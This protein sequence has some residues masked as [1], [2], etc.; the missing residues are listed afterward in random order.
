MSLSKAHEVSRSPNRS[1]DR[2][3]KWAFAVFAAFGLGVIVLIEATNSPK[4]FSMSICAALMITYAGLTYVMPAMRARADQIGDNAY[5]LGL[6]YTLLSLAASIVRLADDPNAAE[7]IL[8]NFGIALVTTILGITLR[9]IIS[10]MRDD[11]VDI[12][13]ETRATLLEATRQFREEL[14]QSAT[15][16]R[17]FHLSLRQRVEESVEESLKTLKDGFGEVA[18]LDGVMTSF[19]ETIRKTAD[20][21]QRIDASVRSFEDNSGAIE[22][23]NQQLTDLAKSLEE[24]N[25]AAARFKTQFGDIGSELA[26][27]IG[28]G[29]G[30]AYATSAKASADVGKALQQLRGSVKELDELSRSLAKTGKAFTNEFGETRETIVQVREELADLAQ[31]ILKRLE[32]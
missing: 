1:Q 21:G 9:V 27:S 2:T 24:S 14:Q 16:M 15:E 18:T 17:H 26:G 30:E 32:A 11:P 8:R 4:L 20:A 6:L 29:L 12:E 22:T 10:Q 23:I 13:R 5:Y 19:A 7:A 31:Y 25:I 28:K 3:G